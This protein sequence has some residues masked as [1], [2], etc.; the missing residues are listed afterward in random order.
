M[1]SFNEFLTEAK[2]SKTRDQA[3]KLKVHHVGRG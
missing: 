1:K 2:V 3:E